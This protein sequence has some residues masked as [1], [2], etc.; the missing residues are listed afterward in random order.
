MNGRAREESNEDQK[1]VQLHVKV[2]LLEVI[3]IKSNI[4]I[5]SGARPRQ[6]GPF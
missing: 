1:K 4:C 3:V 2:Y 6:E 5:F